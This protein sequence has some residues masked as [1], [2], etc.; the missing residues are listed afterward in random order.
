MVLDGKTLG[1]SKR[2]RFGRSPAI[3]VYSLA[4][5]WPR[6]TGAR[7]RAV[8]VRHVDRRKTSSGG[9]LGAAASRWMTARSSR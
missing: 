8:L 2:L 7:V 6:R 9:H 4:S 1:T 5:I 3:L